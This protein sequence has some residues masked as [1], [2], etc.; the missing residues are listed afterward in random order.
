VSAGAYAKYGPISI[1][2]RPEFVYAQNLDF[3]PIPGALSDPYA[4]LSDI[5]IRFGQTSYKKSTLGQSS[6]RLS[7]GSVSL[8]VSNENLWWGPGVQNSL[9]MSNTAPGF[10]HL[11]LNTSAPIRTPIGSFEGQIVSGRLEGSGYSEPNDRWRYLSGIVL[12]Y[13]P[14]WVP[15]LFLG[16]TRTFQ[17]YGNELNR[18]SDYI[19]IIQSFNSKNNSRNAIARDQLTSAF[20]RWFWRP[21]KA[22]IYFEYG[23][24]D[25]S[26]TSRDFILEPEHSRAYLLG[27]RKIS[28]LRFSKG[29]F[30]IGAEYTH[31]Q[32]SVNYQ[33]RS[34]GSWYKHSQIIHGYTHRGQVLGAGIGP[35]SNLQSIELEWFSGQ[36][37]IGL[38]LDRYVYNDDYFPPINGKQLNGYKALSAAI[39][40]S[41]S[42]KRGMVY[43]EFRG[44]SFYI[45][46]SQSDTEMS[47]TRTPLNLQIM[48]GASFLF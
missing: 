22:E 39:N 11:T 36:Q 21:S 45:D 20:A 32:Q 12:S 48:I 29:H 18:N 8:G 46:S 1:Q 43:S 25:H 5:P 37:S 26:A 47:T 16:V 3:E 38:Q 28:N 34:A 27:F 40:G 35:G 44:N 4:G 30:L 2:L 33:I 15:S 6:I 23:R 42:Y 14:R 10:A 24:G 7:L 31:L 9:L 17:V 41:M 13:Q 19:P